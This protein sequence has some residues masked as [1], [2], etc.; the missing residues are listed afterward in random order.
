MTVGTRVISDDTLAAAQSPSIHPLLLVKLEF[1]GGNVSVHSGLGDLVFGG[2]TYTGIGSLGNISSADEV[3]DLS[4]APVSLTLSN[5]PGDM[6]AVVLGQYYQGRKATIFLG[7]LD[8]TTRALIA[9]PTIIHRGRI[10]TADIQQDKTFSVTL[11]VQ[12]R[13]AAWDRPLVRR[14]NNSDQRQRYLTDTG[15]QFI[16]QTADKVVIWGGAL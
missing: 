2:D 16:E 3:S 8:L 7:Y 15:L 11:T 14:Y 10:D 4:N 12:S 6:G 13:F 1:D 9:D 5:I